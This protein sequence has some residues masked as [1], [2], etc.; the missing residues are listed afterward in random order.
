MDE[1]RS[2]ASGNPYALAKTHAVVRILTTASWRYPEAH[3]PYEWANLGDNTTPDW[4]RRVQVELPLLALNPNLPNR[5]NAVWYIYPLTPR[6]KLGPDPDN[7]DLDQ[8][9]LYIMTKAQID[10]HCNDAVNGCVER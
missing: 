2:K 8:N 9:T 4:R 1:L 7:F 6:R 3:R 10:A 5:V